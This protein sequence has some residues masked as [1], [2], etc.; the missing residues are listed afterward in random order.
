MQ[1]KMNGIESL[2]TLTTILP[3]SLLHVL[4]DV[5]PDDRATDAVRKRYP[6]VIDAADAKAQSAGIMER[7]PADRSRFELHGRA[8]FGV[9]RARRN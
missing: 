9:Y 8:R 4:F 3:A 5:F 2:P 6:L 1:V 7:L